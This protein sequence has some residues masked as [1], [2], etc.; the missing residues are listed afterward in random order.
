MHLSSYYGEIILYADA[1]VDRH[2]Q[3][4]REFVEYLGKM[5]VRIRP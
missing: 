2:K 5:A 3:I 4:I 1:N